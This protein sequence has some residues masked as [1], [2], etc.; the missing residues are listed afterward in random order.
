MSTTESVGAL[1]RALVDFTTDGAFPEEDVSSLKLSSE[2]LSPAIKALAEAKS[3]LEVCRMI[4]GR[5]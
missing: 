1:G 5:L 2:E 4:C 3:K